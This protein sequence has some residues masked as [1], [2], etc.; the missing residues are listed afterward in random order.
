T[1]AETIKEFTQ[2]NYVAIEP[3][4]KK[5]YYNLSSAQKRLFI[6]QQMELESTAYNMPLT[7]PLNP[8]TPGGVGPVT[9]GGVSPVT[10][11]EVSP[12]AP[13]ITDML[14]LEKTIRQLI[15][16]HDALRTT[17]HMLEENPVQVVHDTVEFEIEYYN[18]EAP[19]AGELRQLKD[20]TNAFFQ[21]F[22]LSKA[23]LLRIGVVEITGLTNPATDTTATTTTADVTGDGERIMLLDMHHIIT[24]GT[25]QDVLTK[26]F[27]ALY[28]G[29]NLPPLKLQYKDYAEWRTSH[30][31]RQFRKQ[32]EKFWLNMYSDELPILELPLDNPRPAIRSPK[33]K[34]VEFLLK[35]EETQ[36][37]KKI[38]GEYKSTLYMTLLAVFTVLL[39]KLSGQ[40]DII[41]GTPTAGRRHADLQ[42]I[43]GIFLNT[44]PMRNYPSGEKTFQHYLSEI[45]ERTIQAYE[46]QEYQF[47]DLVEKI[48]VTRDTSRNPLFD[49][50]FNLLNIS[51]PKTS[52]EITAGPEETGLQHK[53]IASKF[54]INLTAAENTGAIHFN[55]SYSATLFKEKTINRIIGYFKTIV[56]TV[57]TNPAVIIKAIEIIPETIKNEILTRFNRNL[58]D[59]TPI[60]PLQNKL[61]RAFDKYAHRI[62]LRYGDTE[63]TYQELESKAA[64]ITNRIN[65]NR[66]PKGSFIGIYMENRQEIITAIIGILNAG[67]AF[68]PLDT[69]LPAGRLET[70]IR[71]IVTPVILTDETNEKKISQLPKATTGVHDT[72]GK[73]VHDTGGKG[74]HDTGGKGTIDT[75]II[76]ATF[77]RRNKPQR[78]KIKTLTNQMESAMYVFF[79]SGT[80][81]TPKA[82]VGKNKALSQFIQW[83]METFEVTPSYR[84][85]QLINV[86]FDPYLRDVFTPLCAG[87]AICIPRD[88]QLIMQREKLVRWIEKKGITFIHC[89]PAVFSLFNT[90]NLT[91]GNYK[92]LKYI[93]LS[94]EAL[95]PHELKN[96]YGTIGERVGVVNTYGP[97]EVTLIKMYHKLGKEDTTRT[98]LPVGEA[99]RGSA[100]II[101]DKG[102][103]VCD[104]GQIGEVYIRTPH[105]TYGYCNDP[106]L[107]HQRYIPNPFTHDPLDLVYKTGDL[108]RKLPGGKI[109]L[110]GR[111]D[112]Q[113]KIRGIRIELAEIEAALLKHPEIKKTVVQ[114][115]KNQ[116][117][118]KYLCAYIIRETETR[119][120]ETRETQLR[121]YLLKQLPAYMIPAFFIKIEKIPL[122]PN[123]KIDGK[124]LSQYHTAEIQ[125][126][127]HIA[128][129][130][131]NEEKMT[132]IW[133]GILNIKKEEIGIDNDFFQQ[134]GH[135]LK[136]TAMAA[137]IHKRFNVKLPLT[138]IFKNPTIRTLTETLKE[139]TAAP[140]PEINERFSAIKT[141]EKKEYYTLSSPQKRL[142]I[143]QQME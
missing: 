24:D 21:P 123:G 91:A 118:E 126:Q 73:G 95:N 5:E 90:P 103:N 127:P 58:M 1:L 122:T 136:A 49:T 51:T 7:I 109:E 97:T 81:G 132:E 104:Q 17:F 96:W 142:Y 11:G 98:R 131:E 38:A 119:K 4:E 59:E 57:I 76:N 108:A 35:K 93:S 33:G 18:L 69:T 120:T 25:S 13:G 140:Q 115:D 32:Q 37:L 70:M 30:M 16:R 92:S 68:V 12:V 130:N 36:N 94:G 71:D 133:A 137:R 72:G 114:L 20:V 39:S 106:E 129:R 139:K 100:V 46:N 40:Q 61:A 28:A 105:L 27:F 10:P 29:E 62:A 55:L 138:E 85:S 52:D 45:K 110:L 80:T 128:P 19:K 26:E 50:M 56:K 14:R 6:L 42:N 22:D 79:T 31:F 134:G 48:S 83:E 141:V 86:G 124:A 8:V 116:N 44:L 47:E 89:V 143:L 101:L 78:T 65:R 66:I 82:V 23:P 53:K 121:E 135:S 117:D 77:Y 99:I 34:M 60:S 125:T 74:V 107:T 113:V 43:I 64:A 67:C 112:R 111:K 87:A 41:V 84:V 2:D 54:D 63:L 15:R 75:L 3:T 9:P 102:K 88:N